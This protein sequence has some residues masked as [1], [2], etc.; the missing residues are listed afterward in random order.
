MQDP[1]G[2]MSRIKPKPSQDQHSKFFCYETCGGRTLSNQFIQTH[3]IKL[4]MRSKTRRVFSSQV[5]GMRMA[6]AENIRM[7]GITRMHCMLYTKF[8]CPTMPGTGLR[9][10]VRWVGRCGV[11]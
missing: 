1:G 11:M 10:C 8:Q 6:L 5:Y 4:R 2:A 9:V 7:R 3:F